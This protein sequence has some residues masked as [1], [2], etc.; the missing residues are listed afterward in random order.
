MKQQEGFTMVELIV[1][2]TVAAALAM[3]IFQLTSTINNLSTEAAQRVKASSVAYTNLRLYANGERPN[4]FDCVTFNAGGG[5]PL[6]IY[7]STSAVTGL[8][9]PISQTVVATAPYGCGGANSVGMPIRVQSQIT[10]GSNSRT[11]THATYATY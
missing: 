7:S 5:S 10:Y 9:S 3:S 6:T 11:V 4:W 8:P 1:V 2:I